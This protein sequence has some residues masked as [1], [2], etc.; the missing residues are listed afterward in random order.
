MPFLTLG[1]DMARP[2]RTGG[3]KS[4]AK[5]RNAKPAEGRKAAKPKRRH[6]D[7]APHAGGDTEEARQAA[8]PADT[9]ADRRQHDIARTGRSRSDRCKNGKG[10]N[11]IETHVC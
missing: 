5:A 8:Q 4:A 7:Q 6:E 2:S 1:A 11:L 10:D 9:G 3:K